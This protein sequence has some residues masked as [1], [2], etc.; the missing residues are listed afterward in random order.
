M[1][2]IEK[3]TFRNMSGCDYPDLVNY[4]FTFNLSIIDT[5]ILVIEDMGTGKLWVK[6]NEDF[7]CPF[8]S[9]TNLLPSTLSYKYSL[10][11]DYYQQSFIFSRL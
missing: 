10:V 6:V 1:D 4:T 11:Y 2:I 3:F 5:T 9:N 8:R 7:I